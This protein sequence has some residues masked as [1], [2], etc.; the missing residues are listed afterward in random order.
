[1]KM[2]IDQLLSQLNNAKDD[3]FQQI[4]LEQAVL[5]HEAVTPYLIDI[6]ANYPRFDGA[7]CNYKV[8]LYALYLLAQ[9]KEK[10]AYPLIVDFFM[11]K[12]GDHFLD[13]ECD[14][15]SEGL[16]RII[17]SVCGGDLSLIKQLIENRSIDNDLRDAGLRS[18]VVLYNNGLLLRKDLVA[19]LIYL[20]RNNLEEEKNP[21][22]GASLL[23]YC[24][25]IYPEEFYDLIIMS[26]EKGVIDR[27]IINLDDIDS[28][29]LVG[30]ERVLEQLKVSHHS[31]FITDVISELKECD[32]F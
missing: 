25:N 10:A 16:G 14:L 22:F 11:Q 23:T 6:I 3:S 19:Y 32:F 27:D 29:M 8:F 7:E 20:I 31:Q 17:A 21:L 30:K 13:S 26:Y 28:Q 2:E 4:A 5:Q 15:I 24:I 9:F 18:L 1:M 12:D